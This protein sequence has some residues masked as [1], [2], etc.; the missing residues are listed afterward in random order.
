M[1]E[2][3]YVIKVSKRL[4]PRLVGLFSVHSALKILKSDIQ[5]M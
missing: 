4:A 2:I 5:N 3:I 1:I